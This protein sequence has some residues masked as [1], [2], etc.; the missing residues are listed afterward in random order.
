MEQKAVACICPAISHNT[1]VRNALSRYF[2]PI[3]GSKTELKGIF[4]MTT[5]NPAA[6]SWMIYGVNGYTGRL[7]AEEAIRRGLR[8]VVAGRSAERVA[9]AAG[10]LGLPHRVFDLNNHAETVAGL[11]DVAAV[12]NCAGP[13]SAT[14]RPCLEACAAAGT[15]YLDV[16]GE[17]AVFEH[18]HQ[19]GKRWKD[20]GITAM[21]G[22]GFDVVPTDCMSAM[23]K[24]ALPGATH[25][26]LA[27]KTR[28]GKLSPG[29]T[30]TMIE[31]MGGGKSV[32]R[33][34]VLA[35]AAM[36]SVACEIPYA[37]GPALSAVIAWGDVSTAY[38]STGIPNIEVYTAV[39]EHKLRQ[40]RKMNRFAWLLRLPPVQVFLKRQVEKK[41]K[42]PSEAERA[43]DGT[44]LY[45]DATDA[46]GRRVAMTMHTPNGYTLTYLAAVTSVE[47][48]LA[49][50]VEAGA[51]TPSQAFGSSFVLGLPGVSHTPPAD[52]LS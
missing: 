12:L 34:G 20:A 51:K 50:E 27:F 16:T 14:A 48:V 42:G 33:N 19:N 35:H 41:I 7:C 40:M 29:T 5:T 10:E 30:K 36:G 44:E 11:R 39:P 26:R 23:L 52:V 31:G 32:R 22:V 8:P 38:Y 2:V 17:I 28:K 9:R 37:D 43:A 25:L 21:P 49:G 4:A 15:H 6:N 1:G 46:G 18:V 47:K 3:H 45:G 13:F 24:E